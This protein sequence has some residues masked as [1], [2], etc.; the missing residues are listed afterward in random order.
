MNPVLGNLQ[1]TQSY[2]DIS[3]A[4]TAVAGGDL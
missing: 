3:R 2:H 4:F 1:I